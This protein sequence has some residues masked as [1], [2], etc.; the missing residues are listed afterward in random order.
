VVVYVPQRAKAS[1]VAST[2]KARPPA[3]VA[4]TRKQAP[5][6]AG[7]QASRPSNKSSALAQS[8]RKDGAR[9]ALKN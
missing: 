7:R 8:G 9:V 6:A 1:K 5:R 2:K 4:S 3:R